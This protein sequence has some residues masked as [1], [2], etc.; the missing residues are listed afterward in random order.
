MILS[1]LKYENTC[2][3]IPFATTRAS[4]DT[5]GNITWNLENDRQRDISSDT[6]HQAYSAYQLNR[7]KI[8]TID[9]IFI[10]IFAA[11]NH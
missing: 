11:I 6:D 10:E 3:L 1:N 2:I 9:N 5:N 4:L 7:S 8:S